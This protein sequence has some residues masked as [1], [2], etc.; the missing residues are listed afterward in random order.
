M[1]RL[2][3]FIWDWLIPMT[4]GA[5]LIGLFLAA[6]HRGGW[7]SWVAIALLWAFLL[8]AIVYGFWVDS[9]PW[10]EWDELIRQDAIRYKE[11]SEDGP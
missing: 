6:I 7:A 8:G 11:A 4:V 9:L 5:S 3:K 10:D 1:T 2:S